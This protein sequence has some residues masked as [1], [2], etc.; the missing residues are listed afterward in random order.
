MTSTFLSNAHVQASESDTGEIFLDANATTQASHDVIIS[1]AQAMARG[2][3][4][5]SSVHERGAQARDLTVAAR[6]SVALLVGGCYP[7]GIFFTSGA[8]EANNIALAPMHCDE[9]T[10]LLVASVEHASVLR[11]AMAAQKRRADVRVLR[12]G[13]DGVLDPDVIRAE[14]AS[15]RRRLIVSVQWAN[16]ETGVVQPVAAIAREVRSLRDAFIHSDAVQAVGRM[17]VDMATAG[18]D[19]L[20]LTAH[21]LH[22]PQG[23]G[24]LI[25][26]DPDQYELPPLAFGGD[27]QR[28]LRPGTEPVQLAVGFGVAA[29]ERALNLEVHTSRLMLLR[30]LFE[31]SIAR[32]MPEAEINGS[33]V[34][35]VPNTSNIRFPG[36]DGAVLLARLDDAGI[37]CS[38]GSAC[39]SGRPQPSHVLTA[40]GRS[41]REATESVRFS[42]SIFN[43]KAEAATA[44]AV[45]ASTARS[46]QGRASW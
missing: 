25:L 2:P 35:R 34:T 44:A 20:T 46:L 22:G 30:D 33:G 23:I 11:A 28:G 40:M 4:N 41:E 27:Q 9:D 5:S 32:M 29:R 16:S 17:P 10:T 12:V 21:K 39:S 26:E 37:R 43:T 19:A 6:D 31:S 15:S 42:F 7:E 24:A 14:V 8:T 3:L 38:Q 13:G 36:V 18:I 1:V 45:V